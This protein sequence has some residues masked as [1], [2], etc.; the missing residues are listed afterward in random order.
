VT[1][2]TA[3]AVALA[4]YLL[5]LIWN[6]WEAFSRTVVR[7]WMRHTCLFVLAF[8]TG[9][10]W[11]YLLLVF[12]LGRVLRWLPNPPP[13]DVDVDVDFEEVSPDPVRCTDCGVDCEPRAYVSIPDCGPT[14]LGTLYWCAACARSRLA[15]RPKG[16]PS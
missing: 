6:A 11:P 5:G 15:P 8:F 7:G 3:L 2:T 14:E 12:G 9:A 10:M 13:S 1:S 16:A 4:I